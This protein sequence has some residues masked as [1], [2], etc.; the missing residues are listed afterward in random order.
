LRPAVEDVYIRA[1]DG[2]VTRPVAGY[3][4]R[5]NWVTLHWQDFHLLDP[6]IGFTA[7]SRR[8]NILISL[9]W[10]TPIPLFSMCSIPAPLHNSAENESP[11]QVTGRL[12]NNNAA[13]K[14]PRHVLR[15]TRR[16]RYR[17]SAAPGVSLLALLGDPYNIRNLDRSSKATLLL[18]CGR[19]LGSV[20]AS[21]ASSNP[22]SVAENRSK[23]GSR[24]RC[25]QIE[26][27][28]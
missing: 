22:T 20:A 10:A 23:N 14:S 28:C 11:Q 18:L 12:L 1:S 15:V 4:Y 8:T 7:L 16:A 25:D 21:I 5:A 2:L 6:S 26:T 24:I 3:H 13:Q 9:M 27:G 17:D 19:V